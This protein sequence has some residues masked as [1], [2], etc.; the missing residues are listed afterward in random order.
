QIRRGTVGFRPLDRLAN[1]RVRQLQTPSQRI[2]LSQCR[3]EN[4]P[5]QP[6][7]VRP[8][9]YKGALHQLS[10]WQQ[11]TPQDSE[12]TL[13]ADSNGGGCGKT[14]LDAIVGQALN[15]LLGTRPVTCAQINEHERR[16]RISNSGRTTEIIR[17][18]L[19]PFGR[20]HSLVGITQHPQTAGYHKLTP[21]D[22]S[23]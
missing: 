6:V 15:L 17:P 16:E 7:S 22:V 21:N 4:P 8:E 14:V 20:E 2:P 13:P 9:R 18:L 5:V 10:T 1:R 23:V 12:T 3:T 19:G 11:L